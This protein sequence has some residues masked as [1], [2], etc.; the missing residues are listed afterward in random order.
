M[1]K[2]KIKI[3]VEPIGKRFFLEESTN[4][5]KAIINSGSEIKSLCGGKGICGKCRIIILDRKDIPPNEQEKKIL[6]S[7]EIKRGVG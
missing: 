6:T 4:G 1:P 5:L 3:E 2:K 7:D